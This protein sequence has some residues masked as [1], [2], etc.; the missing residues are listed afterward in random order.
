MN[1][2]IVRYLMDYLTAPSEG[3]VV[4]A[5]FDPFAPQ[6]LADPS[7]VIDSMRDTP[8]FYAPSIG[9]YVVTRYVDIETVLLDEKT[10]SAAPNRCQWSVKDVIERMIAWFEH[11]QQP[12]RMTRQLDRRECRPVGTLTRRQVFHCLNL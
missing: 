12:A 7:A 2:P 6:F 5:D 1:D 4:R 10:Y 3:C 9:Y 11:L 8:V